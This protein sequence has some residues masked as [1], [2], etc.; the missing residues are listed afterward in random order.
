MRDGIHAK[1]DRGVRSSYGMGEIHPSARVED[2]TSRSAGASSSAAPPE[3]QLRKGCPWLGAQ[4]SRRAGQTEDRRVRRRSETRSRSHA[5]TD[6]RRRHAHTPMHALFCDVDLSMHCHPLSLSLSLS[7]P[8]LS[9]AFHLVFPPT[10]M[11]RARLARPA[12]ARPGQ[13]GTTP[14]SLAAPT[15]HFEGPTP[16]APEGRK[17][18]NC[19]ASA[20][21]PFTSSSGASLC[22]RASQTKLGRNDDRRAIF[23]HTWRTMQPPSV[24]PYAAPFSDKVTYFRFKDDVTGVTR[25]TPFRFQG[26]TSCHYKHTFR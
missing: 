16:G 11:S 6:H 21:G 12:S 2:E 3:R 25:E 19:H 20:I 14:R 13:P 23:S 10:P 5:M 15:T 26:Y 22:S 24:R 1:L 8:P 9:P 7:L 18:G 4:L 17:G